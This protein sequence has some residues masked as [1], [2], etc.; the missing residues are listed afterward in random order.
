MF[1]R[2]DRHHH[3]IMHA[4]VQQSPMQLK[5]LSIHT[6]QSE[7]RMSI[8]INPDTSFQQHNYVHIDIDYVPHQAMP[9]MD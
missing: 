9:R 2:V 3:R 8:A 7:T 6:V 1:A 5:S 4:L